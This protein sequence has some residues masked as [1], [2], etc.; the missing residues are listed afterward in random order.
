MFPAFLRFHDAKWWQV[1]GEMTLEPKC[2]A[3]YFGVPCVAVNGLI[4]GQITAERRSKKEYRFMYLLFSYICNLS[5]NC[6]RINFN[7]F[8]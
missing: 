5:K 8:G 2:Q 4:I 1:L 7:Y 3:L 6:W